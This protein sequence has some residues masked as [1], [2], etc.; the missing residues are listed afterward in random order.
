VSRMERG[1]KICQIVSDK[2]NPLR[3]SELD[4]SVV[5][6]NPDQFFRGYTLV[7]CKRHVAEL[8]HLSLDER[9]RFCEEMIRVA[10]ALDRGL[11]P[12]KMNYELLGNISAHMHWHLIP[13]YK[14]DEFWGR[15]VW[16]RRH[17]EKRLTDEEYRELIATIRQYL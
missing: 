12:D 3:I 2:S 17:N 15:P 1:C 5:G 9:T 4:V 8:Y 6:L 11:K 7:V 10:K 13:R 14:N 16:V